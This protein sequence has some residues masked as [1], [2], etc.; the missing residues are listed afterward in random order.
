M[1][2]VNGCQ[3]FIPQHNVGLLWIHK[4]S[5]DHVYRWF[6]NKYNLQG[7]V[8]NAYLYEEVQNEIYSLPQVGKIF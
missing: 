3:K 5:R 7:E 1:L 8:N 4:N 2:H 6:S